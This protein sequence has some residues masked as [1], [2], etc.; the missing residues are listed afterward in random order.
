MFE[1]LKTEGKARRG[2]FTCA[3][4]TVQTPVFM[5]VGTQGAIKGA[6]SA[7]DLKE[8]G[9]QVELSNTYHLHLRPGDQV[10]RQMG[11]L[12]RF[13]RWDLKCAANQ[14]LRSRSGL[15]TARLRRVPGI[16]CRTAADQ[17]EEMPFF[18]IDDAIFG[19]EENHANRW[20][21]DAAFIRHRRLSVPEACG[22][23]WLA[24]RSGNRHGLRRVRGKPGD[25]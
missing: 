19:A 18:P 15:S 3:H 22:A 13:M 24:V 4:G 23:C 14:R 25:L 8:I 5:N 16:P 20:Q 7:H 17:E 11:G 12:H 2:V 9:C 10:V 1:V 21:P 6:V